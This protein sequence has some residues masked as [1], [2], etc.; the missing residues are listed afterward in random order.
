MDIEKYKT[1]QYFDRNEAIYILH[2][3]DK[4]TLE[5]IANNFQ[6]AIEELQEIISLHTKYE[7]ALI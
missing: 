7:A 2:V 6:L 3:V 4:K 1:S 5:E